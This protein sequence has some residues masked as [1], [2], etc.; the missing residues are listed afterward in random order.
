MR[1]S[2]IVVAALVQAAGAFA[3]E[4]FLRRP[5]QHCQRLDGMDTACHRR[6]STQLQQRQQL[7]D[8]DEMCV[9]NVAELCTRA[10]VA[11]SGCDVEEY[12]ALVNQLEDQRSILLEHVDYID[13]LLHKLKGDGREKKSEET[14]IPG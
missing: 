1:L 13:N 11:I 2:L 12:E 9:E 7:D 10:D 14:Y 5:F 8:I 4:A 6:F 3:P